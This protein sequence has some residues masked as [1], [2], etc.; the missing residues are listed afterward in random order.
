MIGASRKLAYS[1]K[2]VLVPLVKV[3]LVTPGQVGGMG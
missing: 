3:S 2:P 1:T